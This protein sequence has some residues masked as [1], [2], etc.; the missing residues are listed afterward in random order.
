MKCFEYGKENS[1][2]MVMLHGGGVCYKGAIPIAE[3]MAKYYHVL[4]WAYDGFNPSEPE[5]EFKS[6]DD[7]AKRLGDYIVS[8]YNGKIDILYGVSY[9]CRVLMAVLADKRLSITTTI[10]DGMGTG[11]YPNLKSRLGKDIYC[12]FFTGFFYQM[13]G[14]AGP[15]RKKIVAKLTGRSIE[16]A[17]RLLY[18]DATWQSWKNQDYYLIGKKT[19]YS[20]FKYTDMYIWHG[21]DSSAEKRLARNMQ[22]LKDTGYP[23]THKI[24]TDVGHGGL[25]GEHTDRFAKEVLAA[26]ARSLTKIHNHEN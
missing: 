1:E 7:E 2:I 24:F 23:F 5:T 9:G 17:E 12:F 6:V 20:L 21:I 25:A 19:D 8:H 22:K 15:V 14:N 26:H 16:E 10:A 13:M 11:E 3:Y 18:Q 4:L